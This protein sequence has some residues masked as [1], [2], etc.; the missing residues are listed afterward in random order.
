MGLKFAT[1]Y[2]CFDE[3]FFSGEEVLRFKQ[4]CF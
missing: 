2:V 3:P 1:G 4:G